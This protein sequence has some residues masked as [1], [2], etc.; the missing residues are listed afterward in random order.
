MALLE[1]R[2]VTKRFGGLVAVSDLDLEVEEGEIRGFIGPNG[3]GKTTLF[4]VISGFDRATGVRVIFQGKDITR[5]RPSLIAQKGLVRTFQLATVFK[6][7]SVLKNVMVG[8]HLH[9][10]NVGQR[11]MKLL[12]FIGL[13]HAKD[14]LANSLTYGQQKALGIA[15]ALAVEPTLLLL[16]EPATG[17]NPE[18]V[19]TMMG[20]ITKIRDLGITLIVVEHHMR[21]IMGL[22]DR[23]TVIDF[24]KKIA[25]GTPKEVTNSK[26]V[27]KAYLGTAEELII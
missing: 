3:A 1:L 22:S 27:I 17:L 26:E 19:L 16:D 6:D 9:P 11:A 15:S 2:K 23:V 14:E 4:N 13:S 18:E 21:L 20:I 25:E 12:E 24:G 8:R 5:S 7:F 10:E